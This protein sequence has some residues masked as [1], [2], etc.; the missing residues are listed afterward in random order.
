M[1]THN[2]TIPE[3]DPDNV[4]PWIMGIQ[5]EAETFQI[6][7]QIG[8]LNYKFDPV[9]H[10]GLNSVI[11]ASLPKSVACPV[12]ISGTHSNPRLIITRVQKKRESTTIENHDTLQ[13]KVETLSYPV[14]TLQMNGKRPHK[15]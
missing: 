5:C 14:L 4:I 7:Q 1:Y 6:T 10:S 15:N 2:K 11:I 3:L 13:T 12:L 9:N 8:D